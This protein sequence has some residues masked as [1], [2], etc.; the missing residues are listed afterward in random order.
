MATCAPAETA[1]TITSSRTSTRPPATRLGSPIPSSSTRTARRSRLH[2]GKSTGPRTP[3]DLERA[4]R[5]NWKHGHYSAEAKA[6]RRDG[7][8]AARSL[9][10]L[11]ALSR[12][13]LL[14][15]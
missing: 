9:R 7:R 15:G 10:R 14:F 3:E 12:L 1:A 2:G 8:E 5:S 13:D 6:A 4:R 11:L